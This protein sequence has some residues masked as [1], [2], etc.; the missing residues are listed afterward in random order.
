[1]PR[2]LRLLLLPAFLFPISNLPAA[3]HHPPGPVTPLCSR[4]IVLTAHYLAQS[5]AGEQSGF[6]FRID[7]DS[8]KPILLMQ[9]VPTSAHWYAHV[10]SK[11]LWRSSSGSGG[12]YVDAINEHGA[13][14]AYRPK[15]PP[16]DPHY[17][18][19]PAH[20]HAEWMASE[21]NNAALRYRP[22][23]QKCNYPG[24]TE[25]KAVFAY[26]YLPASEAPDPGLLTCGLRSNF[27]DMPPPQMIH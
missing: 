26:A 27:V 3:P 17:L 20:G 15:Q 22:G 5:K 13:L 11:W 8:S 10:G 9:P 1:M 14:F 23:C 7:N 18:T 16:S 25:Y 6:L 12:S 2:A 24:E 21:R 4:Q 19:I